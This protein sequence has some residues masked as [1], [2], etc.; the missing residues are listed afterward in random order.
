MFALRQI[1]TGDILK[2]RAVQG[3]LIYPGIDES[4]LE[5]ASINEGS[6]PAHDEDTEYLKLTDTNNGA[7]VDRTYA[8]TA[9]GA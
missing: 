5:W 1:S 6:K 4:D 9:L 2:Q 8:V 7:V 3:A